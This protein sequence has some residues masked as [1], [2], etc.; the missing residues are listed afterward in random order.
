MGKMKELWQKQQEA[1]RNLQQFEQLEQEYHFEQ[2]KKW[3]SEC[4]DA[5]LVKEIQEWERLTN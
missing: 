5:E 4:D 1:E 3:Q 2:W